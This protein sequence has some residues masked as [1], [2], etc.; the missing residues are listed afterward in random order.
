MKT[1]EF[2]FAELLRRCT[3]P[4][5][6]TKV[7][8]AVSGGADSMALM[9][10][11]LEAGCD[12][13]VVHVDHGLRSGESEADL[14]A[15]TAARF[16]AEFV[17]LQTVVDPGPNLEARARK[18]R[19]ELLPD[20]V[21]TG[22]TADDQAETVLLNLLRG[23]GLDGLC[24]MRRHRHPILALRRSETVAV[25]EAKGIE[26]FTDPTNADLTIRRNRVRLQLRPVLDGIAE[27]DVVPLLCRFAE[28]ARDDVDL[29][30]SLAAA[31]DPSDA[32]A[33][34]GAPEPLARRAL[35]SWVRAH[36]DDE[37]HPPSLKSIDRML[38]VARGDAIACEIEGGIRI[39]RTN[40]RMRIE[41][42][43]A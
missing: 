27:R 39:A 1:S 12:V 28:L 38:G 8:C 23:S 9:V 19:Y 7:Q 21:L 36:T 17:G 10:L 43:D 2:S 30:D 13:T 29:L 42:P 31:L 4:T 35:R 3:F 26:Y 33:V 14:V 24:G 32:R 34:A 22:H 15:A 6:G 18:A 16:G 41:L 25:C 40:Q 11:A 37:A 20:N 5:S